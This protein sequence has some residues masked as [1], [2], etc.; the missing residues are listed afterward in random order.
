MSYLLNRVEKLND[1]AYSA[2]SFTAPDFAVRA[3]AIK[4]FEI[5]RSHG[6]EIKELDAA[7]DILDSENY[8]SLARAILF[9]IA[10]N[11]PYYFIKS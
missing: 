8:Y 7:A 1:A 9:V 11:V 2:L 4:A 6:Y 10:E 3:A 5:I